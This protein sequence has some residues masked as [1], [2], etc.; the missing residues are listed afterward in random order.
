MGVPRRQEIDNRNQLRGDLEDSIRHYIQAGD[1]LNAKRALD[2]LKDDKLARAY[3]EQQYNKPY[4]DALKRKHLKATGE[5]FEGSNAELVESDFE[6]WGT[7]LSSLGTIRPD[8]KGELDFAGALPELYQASVNMSPQEKKDSLLM[9]NTYNDTSAFNEGSRPGPEQFKQIVSDVALDPMTAATLGVGKAAAY[10]T[11]PL[12]AA[13]IKKLYA[14]GVAF[15]GASALESGSLDYTVQSMESELGG[16]D[17]SLPQTA[18]ATG[19]GLV[20]PKGTQM[21]G[22]LL[23]GVGRAV[24]HPI[25]ATS[26]LAQKMMSKTAPQAAATSILDDASQA[27]ASQGTSLSGGT[28]GFQRTATHLLDDAKTYWRESFDNFPLEGVNVKKLNSVIDEWRKYTVKSEKRQHPIKFEGSIDISLE[29]LA[30]GEITPAQAIREIKGAVGDAVSSGYNKS[31]S[32]YSKSTAENILKP[33]LEKIR[34][35]EDSAAL[36]ADA[37]GYTTLKKDFG[38]WTKVRDSDFGK[39]FIK[40]A[41]PMNPKKA[42]ELIKSMFKGDFNWAQVESF[43]K[44]VGQL[45][46][47]MSKGGEYKGSLMKNF[48]Q[49]AGAFLLDKPNEL[50][51]LLATKEGMTILKKLYPGQETFWKSIENM[52]KLLPKSQGGS[53]VSSNLATARI[54][55]SLGTNITGSKHGGDA[56]LAFVMNFVNKLADKTWFQH[57]MVNSYKRRGGRLHTA[58]RTKLQKDYDIDDETVDAIQDYMWG[59]PTAKLTKTMLN[60]ATNNNPQV[61]WSTSPEDKP[62]VKY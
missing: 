45:E 55:G 49:A 40:A 38:E 20:A 54:V 42:G 29:K 17:V 43:E 51:K 4:I 52:N 7:T 16:R 32:T 41:D 3:D 25:Q 24:T 28:R 26:D 18:L 47:T 61:N 22:Q 10:L 36:R 56:A 8:E 13:G 12:V 62:S 6:H 27:I 2:L 48:Q 53:M 50:P 31:D 60:Y 33:V 57:A 9:F 37:K 23:G 59:L 11:K 35:I 5:A 21:A 30:L 44:L 14:P 58:V 46:K 34:K 1:K 39:Q 15:A 19:I